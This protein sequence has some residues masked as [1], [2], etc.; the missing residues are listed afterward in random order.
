MRK[1]SLW[2]IALSLLPTM[3]APVLGQ[4]RPVGN[5][6]RVNGTTD[7]KQRNPVASFN[8]GGSSL[9]V[10][11]NDRKGLRGRLY[12]RDGSPQTDELSLVANQTLA[13]VPSHGLEVLRREPA[14]AFLASGEFLLAW[15]EERDEVSADLFLETRN[16][17]DRDVYAQRFSA[18]GAPQGSPV[19]LNTTAAGFQSNPK[20]LVRNGSDVLAVWQSDDRTASRQG[21]GVFGR[22]LRSSTA[23]PT[24]AELKLSSVPGFAANAS[25]AGLA[26]GGFAVAWEAA[27]ADSQGVFVR[28]FDKSASPRGPEFRVNTTVAGLQRRPAI[29]AD[30][31]TGGYLVVWQGQ[32][33]TIKDSHIYGQFLGAGG[34]FIGPQFQ[35]SRGV[36]QGQISPSVAGIG[37]HF[38]VTWLDYSDIFPVG[39]FSV[40]IDRLGG[41]IGAEVQVNTE[42]VNAQ[43]RTSIALSPLGGVLIP[44]EGFTSNPD[45]PGIAARRVDF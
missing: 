26:N 45:S 30:A 35:A 34:S 12:G 5:E 28:L 19:R 3:A 1:P 39:V 33:G 16:V 11:E 23:Q 41:A 6:F 40:E 38:L 42:P 32:A 7:F 4:P 36:A 25:L 10:W 22:L 24:S 13:R 8:A 43:S 27:D 15:T 21:D 18:A 37:G 44:W 14:V 20:L 29:T 31:N 9:V 17:L 2:L